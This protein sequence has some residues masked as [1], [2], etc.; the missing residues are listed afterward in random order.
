MMV[1]IDTSLEAFNEVKKTLAK[2]QAEVY[3]AIFKLP[4]RTSAE[5][6][7]TLLLPLRSVAPRI[8]EML[9]N[10]LIKRYDRRICFVT[11]S[12]AYTYKVI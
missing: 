8:T 3:N 6:A 2:R 1:S 10:N 12:S 11:G 5:Y 9:H 7:K 4:N